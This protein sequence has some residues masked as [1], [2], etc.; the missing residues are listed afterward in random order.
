MKCDSCV[1]IRIQGIICHEYGCSNSW[2]DLNT[3][4]PYLVDCFECGC[5]FEPEIK[6]QNYCGCLDFDNDE[7]A[8]DALRGKTNE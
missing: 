1:A 2:I 5:D 6:D 3:G 7:D 4:K 8:F